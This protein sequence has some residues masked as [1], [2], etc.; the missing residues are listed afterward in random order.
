M[1]I[2]KPTIVGGPAGDPLL[3]RWAE[4]IRIGYAY[5][6]LG[7]LATNG[8][9][10]DELER[11]AAFLA[12]VGRPPTVALERPDPDDGDLIYVFV[13]GTPADAK[14]A[15]RARGLTHTFQWRHITTL[16]DLDTLAGFDPTDLE[17]VTL[18]TVDRAIIDALTVWPILTLDQA[19]P[20]RP[21]DEV[22]TG[23]RL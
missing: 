6:H 21:I 17:V 4:L 23:G 3:A 13:G 12:G 19:E 8:T 14:L 10:E 2:Y 1:T 18:G 22:D 15:A 20:P 11:F 16:D 5:G 7:D 9:D